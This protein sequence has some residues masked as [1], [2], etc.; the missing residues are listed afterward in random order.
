MRPQHPVRVFAGGYSELA[1]EGLSFRVVGVLC[2]DVGVRVHWR[3]SGIP[4]AIADV[5]QNPA[6]F[7]QS[8]QQTASSS[9]SY[10]SLDDDV[11]TVYVADG[12]AIEPQD[13][14]EWAGSSFF[15]HRVPDDASELLVRWQGEVIAIEIPPVR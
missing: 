11:D 3:L 14:G 6:V 10:I 8:F 9:I 4:K 5:L 12:S 2:F 13:E 7:S 1:K 15:R